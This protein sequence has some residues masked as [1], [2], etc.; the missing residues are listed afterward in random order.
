M[1]Q[2]KSKPFYI[3]NNEWKKDLDVIINDSVIEKVIYTK[4]HY[5]YVEIQHYAKIPSALIDHKYFI[6][7]QGYKY[8]QPVVCEDV[9]VSVYDTPLDLLLFTYKFKK[10]DW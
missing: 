7:Y 6:T 4:D 3:D 5:K 9:T 1:K 10:L 8:Y 2:A